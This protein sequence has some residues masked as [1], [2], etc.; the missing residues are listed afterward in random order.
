MTKQVQEQNE[1]QDPLDEFKEPDFAKLRL[2]LDEKLVYSFF[3][4]FSRFEHALKRNNFAKLSKN[5]E[6]VVGVKWEDY[7]KTVH[8]PL[9]T[10]SHK[11]NA[12]IKY[13]CNN[14]VKKL[15]AD[16][17]WD[18][19][20]QIQPEN[21]SEVILEIPKIRNNLFHG[22]K[23]LKVDPVRDNEL[24]NHAITMLKFCLDVNPDL[25]R[26]FDETGQ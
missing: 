7:S 16:G 11:V 26:E 12:A 9:P 4:Y 2:G 22:S 15:K 1:K 19:Q 5:G 6:Y 3:N 20:P 24:L 17:T 13:I 25:R 21:T 18:P 14:P 10:E 8:I 23:Y